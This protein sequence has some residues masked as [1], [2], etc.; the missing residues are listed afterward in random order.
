M[1]HYPNGQ[2]HVCPRLQTDALTA[3]VLAVGD[4]QR[5]SLGR[6]VGAVLAVSAVFYADIWISKEI[7]VLYVRTPWQDDPYDAVISF[8]FV[9]VP[10]LACLAAVR[11]RLCRRFEPLPIRRALN[12][13]QICWLLCMAMGVTLGSEWVNLA[14]GGHP[15]ADTSS[16][17]GLVAALVMMSAAVLT[18]TIRLRKARRSTWAKRQAPQQPDWLAD[19]V[20]LLEREASRFGRPGAVTARVARS[21]DRSLIARV[22]RHPL[23]ATAAFAVALSLFTDSP[24]IVLEG[25]RP[26]LAVWFVAVSSCSVFAFVVIAARYLHLIEQPRRRSSPY[27]YASVLTTLCVPVAASFRGSLWWIVGTNDGS[28]GLTQLVELTTVIPLA[29]GVAAYV[30]CRLIGKRRGDAGLTLY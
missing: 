16:S 19:A 3:D 2:H 8:M 30:I 15:L 4:L 12:L 10:L 25:Y 11:I 23:W 5:D 21:I 7:P 18:V 1:Q 28:A 17:I 26:T 22:R 9:A 20:T 27:V 29:I 13:V 24:Q 14:V 6:A